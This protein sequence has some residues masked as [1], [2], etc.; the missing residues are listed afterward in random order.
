MNITVT[1]LDVG[2]KNACKI[3]VKN[4]YSTCF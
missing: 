1:K 3:T 2:K 4:N